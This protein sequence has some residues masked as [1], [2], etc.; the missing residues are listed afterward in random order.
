MVN[1]RI[2]VLG[3]APFTMSMLRGYHRIKIFFLQIER[4]A[5]ST[6]GF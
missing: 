3:E 2:A 6:P 4:T 5:F 1:D